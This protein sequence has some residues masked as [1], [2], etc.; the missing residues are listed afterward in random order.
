MGANSKFTVGALR[1][2]VQ[3]KGVG[4]QAALK[5]SSSGLC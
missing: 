5:D 1:F 4:L 3:G 2:C